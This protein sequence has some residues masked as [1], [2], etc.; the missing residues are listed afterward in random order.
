MLTVGDVMRQI[1]GIESTLKVLGEIDDT[2][3]LDNEY[4]KTMCIEAIVDAMSH[5]KCYIETLKD[6]TI[7]K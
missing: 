6:L 4:G 1:D 3:S 7:K 2:E 5:L